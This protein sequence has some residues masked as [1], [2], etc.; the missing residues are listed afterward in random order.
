MLAQD[1]G[2][3]DY[4]FNGIPTVNSSRCN[5]AF[6][7]MDEDGALEQVLR[8]SPNL[9][10]EKVQ[11]IFNVNEPLPDLRFEWF[12]KMKNVNF[13]EWF[14]RMKNVKVLYLGRW[15]SSVQHHNE[16]QSSGQHHIEVQST[17]FL[18][19]LKS[20]KCL[21][22]LSLQGISRINKLPD[23]IRKLKNLS[24]LDLKACHNLEA[25]PDGIAS[26]KKLL[27]FNISECYLLDGMPKGLASLSELQVLKGFVIGNLK[28]R[29]SCTLEDLIGLK[30]LN[31][32]SINTSSKAFPVEKDLY[33]LRKLEALQKLA[34]AWSDDS[35]KQENAV[36]NSVSTMN[37]DDRRQ[38][39][40]TAKPTRAP[41]R[42]S[43][44][45]LIRRDPET[46]ELPTKLEKL[47]LQC[48]PH[49]GTPSWLIPGKL[50]SLKKLY[51]RGGKLN[52]LRQIQEGND[53]WTVEILRLKYLDEFNM[54]WNE[55]HTSFPKLIFLETVECVNLSS[56][57][58][59]EFG[60]W[61]KS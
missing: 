23:S 56:C 57:P 20:L 35:T 36:L 43:S 18:K 3:F 61:L 5:R 1:A 47:E 60:V 7:M 12:A 26:L 48:F 33:A 34:I 50:Q 59:D 55:L 8:N 45:F 44:K 32:L 53:K 54:N 31:K 9:D 11:T 27:H 17:E 38:D 37:S 2:F 15:Q 46:L 58:C 40:G 29:S 19:G 52:N 14:S 51:I 6:L 10:Q 16:E 21:R 25:L 28:S 24:I 39:S 41:S 49:T 13:V 42:L 4:H 22:L 30:K